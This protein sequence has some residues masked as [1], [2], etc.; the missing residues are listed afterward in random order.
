MTVIIE[1]EYVRNEGGLNI[2][3]LIERA[4]L[5]L[6]AYPREYKTIYTLQNTTT[7][8]IS[9]FNYIKI[10]NKFIQDLFFVFCYLILIA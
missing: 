2:V 9:H 1:V 3:A 5:R 10:C 8:F 6:C 4:G 7:W